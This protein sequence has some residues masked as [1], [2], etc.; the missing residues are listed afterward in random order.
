MASASAHSDTPERHRRQSDRRRTPTTPPASVSDAQVP[1]LCRRNEQGSLSKSAPLLSRHN[2]GEPLEQH[3]IHDTRSVR[4]HSSIQGCIS[5]Q[6][7][8]SI[9]LDHDGSTTSG[10]LSDSQAPLLSQYDPYHQTTFPVHHPFTKKPLELGDEVDISF[11]LYGT[12][13]PNWKLN[14]QDFCPDLV[15]LDTN[16]IRCQQC[17]Q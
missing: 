3:H 1:L 17:F 14:Y 5:I 8:E 11:L 15:R 2:H 7:H 16:S 4:D 6:D 9:H 10:P 13:A 12:S